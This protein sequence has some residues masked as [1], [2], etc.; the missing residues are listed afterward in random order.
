M[1]K[2]EEINIKTS[3]LDFMCK[4]QTLKLTDEEKNVCKKYLDDKIVTEDLLKIY[5]IM[6]LDICNDIYYGSD[7][8]F[9]YKN[10][11]IIGNHD[12]KT[13][14]STIKEIGNK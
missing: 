5:C 10:K 6:D 11:Y 8:K 3:E 1:K 7:V 2:N 9:L 14:K 13:N 12:L 4:F